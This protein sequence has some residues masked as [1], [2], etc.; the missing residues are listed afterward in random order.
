MSVALQ[1][2]PE[3]PANGAG[4]PA[5][6]TNAGCMPDLGVWL[7]LNSNGGWKTSDGRLIVRP[8]EPLDPLDMLLGAA[9]KPEITLSPARLASAVCVDMCLGTTP[10]AEVAGT[11]DMATPPGLSCENL[12][13][14]PHLQNPVKKNLADH[15]K[16]SGSRQW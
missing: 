16:Q 12:Q 9:E 4:G 15:R 1:I 6:A 3:A 7:V 5:G 10:V 11:P 8:C 13:A 14:S 2:L